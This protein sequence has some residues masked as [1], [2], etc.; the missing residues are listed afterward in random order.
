VEHCDAFVVHQLEELAVQV[1]IQLI[2]N[3]GV[4]RLQQVRPLVG[5]DGQPL[6]RAHPVDVLGLAGAREVALVG[7]L[8]LAR[9]G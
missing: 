3:E 7:T 1:R 2:E 5:P 6:I 4:A 8:A 9:L